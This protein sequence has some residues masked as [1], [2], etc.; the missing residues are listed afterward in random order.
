M[1][2]YTA[3]VL[4]ILGLFIY[5]RALK[6]NEQREEYLKRQMDY[7]RENPHMIEGVNKKYIKE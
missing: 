5:S 6:A 4:V 2:Y 1:G 3:L 7:F